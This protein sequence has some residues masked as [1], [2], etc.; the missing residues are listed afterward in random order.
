M[1]HH[2]QTLKSKIIAWFNQ[3]NLTC[4]YAGVRFDCAMHCG[5]APNSAEFHAAFDSVEFY[6]NGPGI[7]RACPYSY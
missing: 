1:S 2:F 4:F 7:L 5:V 6:A 3:E